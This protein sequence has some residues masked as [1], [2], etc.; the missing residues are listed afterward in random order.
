MEK[1]FIVSCLV[2]VHEAHSLHDSLRPFIIISIGPFISKM[3]SL[4]TIKSIDKDNQ[5]V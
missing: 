1:R 5:S 4:S 3:K 2:F